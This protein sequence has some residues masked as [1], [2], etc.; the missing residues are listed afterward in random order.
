MPSV[1]IIILHIQKK[2]N[3][4]KKIIDFANVHKLYYTALNEWEKPS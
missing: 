1:N 2:N 4:I 3:R